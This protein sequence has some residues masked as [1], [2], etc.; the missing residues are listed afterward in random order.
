MEPISSDLGTKG[1]RLGRPVVKLQYILAEKSMLVSVLL[2]YVVSSYR[3]SLI[4]PETVPSP[5]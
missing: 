2:L 4:K 1:N 3:K 5:G